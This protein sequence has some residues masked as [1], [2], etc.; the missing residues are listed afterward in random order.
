MKV[1]VEGYG[2][3]LN[4]A[5]TAAIKALL[6]KNSCEFVN[7]EKADIIIINTCAV[8]TPTENKMLRRIKEL[9]AIKKKE[10]KIIVFGCL[11]KIHPEAVRKIDKSVI[12]IGPKL[13]D[14]CRF[15]GFAEKGFS[16]NMD[17]EYENK[18]VATI[19]IARGCLGDCTY[20][21]VKNARGKLKSYKV[22][23]IK[24][25]VRKALQKGAKEIRLTAQDVGCYG[26]DIGTNIVELL[27]YV[28]EIEGE[29]RIRLGMM[30][31]AHVIDIK[32]DLA[33]MLRE[34]RV[35]RF[36]HLPVQSGSNKILKLMNRAYSAEDFIKLVEFLKNK[37]RDITIAT[38]IIVGFPYEEEED[39]RRTVELLETVKPDITN[40]SKYGVRPR[41][42][43]AKFKQVDPKI[44]KF[45]SSVVSKLAL[46][47]SYENNKMLVGRKGKILVVEKGCKGNFVG[48]M[49]NYKPV[50]IREN[51]IGEFV[52]VEIVEAHPCY[53]EGVLAT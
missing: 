20:C 36:L 42:L 21:C 33:D 35:Y 38:D 25:G 41:T 50:V 47:L 37:V 22:N 34:E 51:R 27:G 26:F 5:D 24:D 31:P 14:L 19:P 16:P 46:R 2:C 18:L 49:Q 53:L 4:Q 9:E 40:V 6:K 8:K 3:S 23:E 7:A 1:Y 32:K 48:R 11:P 29:Y 13:E 30:N 12:L 10:A 44:K 45:R 39:F 15:F 52:G 17:M 28:L 43:A